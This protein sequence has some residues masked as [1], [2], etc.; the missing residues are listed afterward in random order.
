MDGLIK[1]FIHSFFPYTDHRLPARH[2]LSS[3]G[4]SMYNI[5]ASGRGDETRAQTTWWNHC[6]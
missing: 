2:Y 6:H 1:S 5:P 3:V 4:V